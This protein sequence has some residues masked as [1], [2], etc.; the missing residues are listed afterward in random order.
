M[1]SRV[2]LTGSGF[3]VLFATI[4]GVESNAPGVLR[5]GIIAA[6]AAAILMAQR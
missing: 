5:S 1:R 6:L 3:L 4:A 2:L